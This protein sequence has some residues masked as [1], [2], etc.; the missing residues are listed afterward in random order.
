VIIVPGE[1][2]VPCEGIVRLLTSNSEIDAVLGYYSFCID[3]PFVRRVVSSLITKIMNLIS[4]C[5]LKYANSP[6]KYRTSKIPKLKS[7]YFAIIAEL[8]SKLA[9]RGTRFCVSFE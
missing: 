9:V 2:D 1:G 3:R 5:D 6:G 8:N 7:K 4:G